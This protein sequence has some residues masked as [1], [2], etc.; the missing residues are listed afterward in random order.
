[1]EGALGMAGDPR[2]RGHVVA[3]GEVQIPGR[4]FSKFNGCICECVNSPKCWHH[5]KLK[6]H[7]KW[8]VDQLP[9]GTFRWTTPSGRSDTTEPTRY[10]I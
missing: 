7:P 10:P 2:Q 9:D 1:M 8:Q 3:R 6:Q 5:H 4:V